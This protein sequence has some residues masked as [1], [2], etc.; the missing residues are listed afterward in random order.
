MRNIQH[1]SSSIELSVMRKN[2]VIYSFVSKCLKIGLNADNNAKIDQ[3]CHQCR[4]RRCHKSRWASI[5]RRANGFHID[6]SHFKQQPSQRFIASDARARARGDDQPG[7]WIQLN[8]NIDHTNISTGDRRAGK[9][10]RR[11]NSLAC[12]FFF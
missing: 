12:V 9:G 6:Y 11:L 7:A 10:G 1:T 8:N 4:H 2:S 3:H 5:V